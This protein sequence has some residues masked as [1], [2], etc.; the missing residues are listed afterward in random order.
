LL[1]T[2]KHIQVLTKGGK[3]FINRLLLQ[4]LNAVRREDKR[5]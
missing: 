1:L 5:L 3:G 4:G 2:I